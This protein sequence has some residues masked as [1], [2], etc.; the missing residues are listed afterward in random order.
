MP[1]GWRSK[2]ASVQEG[3][4]TVGWE[5]FEPGWEASKRQEGDSV[6]T[7]EFRSFLTELEGEGD[8]LRVDEP[9]SRSHE[10]AAVLY[11]L[12]RQGG[13]AVLMSNVG[14]AGAGVVGNVLGTRARFAKALN[15]PSHQ[16]GAWVQKKRTESV[17]WRSLSDAPFREVIQ[18][19]GI[20]LRRDLPA[21][22]HAAKDSSPYITAGVLFSRHPETEELNMA[23][24][25]VGVVGS[26]EV[27]L[28]LATDPT[29]SHYRLA[30]Q[31]K[32]DLEVAIA[33]GVAPS[34]LIASCTPGLSGSKLGFAGA[35]AGEGVSLAA[36]ETVDVE[37]PASAE[38]IIEGRIDHQRSALDGSFGEVSG[39]YM[40]HPGLV[41]SITAVARRSDALYQGLHPV[42]P[43]C[44]NLLRFTAAADA[45]EKLRSVV[46][47]VTGAEVHPGMLNDLLVV[48]VQKQNDAEVRQLLHLALVYLGPWFKFAVAVD[49][50]VDI[51]SLD[52]VIWALLTRFRPDRDTV[53]V[54]DIPASL[55]DPSCNWDEF[56][57]SKMGLDATCKG[58]P[59]ERW[60]RALAPEECRQKAEALVGE[61]LKNSV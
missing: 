49:E 50:D 28:V 16:I 45:F 2:S 13:P 48:R 4:S 55:L 19:D 17:P 52:D 15:V 14:G 59:P 7:T 5:E 3:S 23:I 61:L 1:S 22:V 12:G 46:P 27:T 31:R 56:S 30:Q 60:E 21:L 36:C 33:V 6:P 20:D 8:L 10:V 25:R 39:Y 38:W 40:S 44:A 53:I 26:D 58:G 41:M 32:R 51:T 54:K 35:L 42:S 47:S 18:K 57:G 37:V 43:E 34:L 11:E 24:H 29:L 9:L